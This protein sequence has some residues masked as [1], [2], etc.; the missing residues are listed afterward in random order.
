[1][2]QRTRGAVDTGARRGG[3]PGASGRGG[4]PPV[5][6]GVTRGELAALRTRI[7]AEVDPI[8][9]ATGLDLEDLSVTR[10]G[11]RHVIQIVVDGDG[12]VDHDELSGLSRDVSAALDEV[13]SSGAEIVPGGYTLEVSSPGVDRPLTEPRHWRRNVGR[14]V[15][16]TAEGRGLTARVVAVDE[17]GVTFGDPARTVAFHALG[18]GRVQLEFSRVTELADDEF[19]GDEFAAGDEREEEGGS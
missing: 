3:S 10:V 18:S 17:H 14:L 5:A 11:R 15:T 9:S 16:V 19:A 6:R 13:E 2:A 12:G 4:E 8:V 1:M 7:R